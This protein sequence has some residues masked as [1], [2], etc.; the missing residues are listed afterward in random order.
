M[1][2]IDRTKANSFFNDLDNR[3]TLILA[4]QGMRGHALYRI[5]ASHQEVWWD[6]SIMNYDKKS[7]Y[8]SL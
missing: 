3:C 4:A 6:S 1:N 2:D 8:S 7:H 5:L